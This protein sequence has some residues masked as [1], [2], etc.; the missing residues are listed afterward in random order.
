M[1]KILYKVIYFLLKVF[2]SILFKLFYSVEVKG[3]ENIPD[4]GPSIVAGN[5]LSYLDGFLL[6]CHVR[7]KIHSLNYKIHNEKMVLED[8]KYYFIIDARKGNE[9][10]SNQNYYKYGKI[11]IDKKDSSLKKYLINEL[12][13]M[14]KVI[15][16]LVLQS[17]E[18]AILRIKELEEEIIFINEVLKCL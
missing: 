1:K 4:D 6:E 13:K 2:F 14:E 11:L 10:Y 7:K 8:G 16:K 12:D 17:T 9:K 18:N 3:T 15:N 5:H